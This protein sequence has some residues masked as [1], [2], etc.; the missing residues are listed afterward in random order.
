MKVEEHWA[1]I[2]AVFKNAQSSSRYCAVAT[3]N[4]DGSPHVTPI[5]SLFLR[6]NCTGYYFEEYTQQIPNNL[7][8][9][10]HVCILAV[11]SG[12]IYWFK[13]VFT[14]RF[15]T[16]PGV[17]L[18]G[19]VGER[20]EATEEEIMSFQNRVRT[21]R[22]LKGYKLIWKNL[23]HIREVHFDS[24]EPVSAAKMTQHLWQG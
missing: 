15:T 23:K 22:K 6:D 18:Y 9:N 21:A 11:D 8:R 14:G 10:K 2:Q 24:F 3:V 1:E 12:W 5:G 7:K 20:R 17:R 16:P 19:T 4:E 13:S